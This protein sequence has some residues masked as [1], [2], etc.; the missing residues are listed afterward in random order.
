M[1][2]FRSLFSLRHSA[3]APVQ[4]PKEE[5]LELFRAPFFSASDVRVGDR[6]SGAPLVP[7]H[8]RDEVTHQSACALAWIQMHSEAGL[9][10][11]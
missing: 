6:G 3:S 1:A 10:E 9:A 2:A 5:Y 8:Q 11:G 7:Q 4:V